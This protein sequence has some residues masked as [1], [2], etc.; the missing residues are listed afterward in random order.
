MQNG[1]RTA[2][3]VFLFLL[4]GCA[5]PPPATPFIPPTAARAPATP[6]VE[7]VFVTP[8]PGELPSETPAPTP[9]ETGVPASPTPS[10]FSNL[11][12]LDDVNYPDGS[13]FAPG[14]SFEKQWL[15]ENNGSCD[16][17]TGYTLRFVSGDPLGATG[18]VAIFPARAASQVTLSIQFTAPQQPGLYRSTWQPFDPLGQP[19]GDSFYV[20]I[21]VQSP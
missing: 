1:F 5:T 15:V 21:V 2:C 12:Y 17:G 9:T 16:W 13:L 6:T 8:T 3:C 4:T 7:V 11:R 14:Q 19:F 10:C 20:E 18:E